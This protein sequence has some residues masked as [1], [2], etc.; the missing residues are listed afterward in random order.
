MHSSKI[1]PS[2]LDKKKILRTIWN[3]SWVSKEKEHNIKEHNIRGRKKGLK[4]LELLKKKIRSAR[5]KLEK[6]CAEE[7]KKEQEEKRWGRKGKKG[8]S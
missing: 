6:L 5:E 1:L 7:K 8:E 3:R 4:R 2:F